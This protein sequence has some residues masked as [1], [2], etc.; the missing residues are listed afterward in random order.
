MMGQTGTYP[1]KVMLVGEYGVV[2]GG[3][4]LT[5]PFHHFYARV[6]D[7]SDV[8]L[9]KTGE[10]RISQRYLAELYRYIEALPSGTFHAEPDLDL[11]SGQLEK[12]WLEMTIPTGYGLGSSGTVSAAVYDLFFPEARNLSLLQQKED[13]ASIESFF[14]GKSSG[15]DALTCH[16][17]KS[18]RFSGDSIIEVVDFDPARIPGGYRF[19]LLDSG[20]RFDTGPLVRHFLNEMK[21]PGFAASIMDEYL[22]INQKLIEALLGVREADPG[23]LVRVLSDYQFKNFRKM[24]PDQMADLWIEGQVTNEYYLKLNGSGGGFMLGITHHTQMESL[25]ERWKGQIIWIQ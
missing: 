13:L 1:S 5:I 19:F 8:P 21:D 16:A 25:E 15:V 9:D 23:L 18:L 4:A 3:S 10:V 6:R 14:H 11:F 7:L 17:G 20:E 22:A 12:Y 24:I 2:V